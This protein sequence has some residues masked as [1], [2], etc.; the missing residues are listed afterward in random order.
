MPTQKPYTGA[1]NPKGVEH[2]IQTNT[3]LELPYRSSATQFRRFPVEEGMP[4]ACLKTNT[5]GICKQKRPKRHDRTRRPHVW[6]KRP[7]IQTNKICQLTDCIGIPQTKTYLQHKVSRI[8]YFV[9]S[10]G[11]ASVRFS[12][13]ACVPKDDDVSGEVEKL[14]ESG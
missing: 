6:I 5:I 13:V 14:F 2:I 4:V 1:R 7:R 9:E 10:C 12:Q 3:V 11:P 8:W